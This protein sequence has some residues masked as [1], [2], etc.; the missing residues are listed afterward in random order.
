MCGDDGTYRY[1]GKLID[2]S[3]NEASQRGSE[4]QRNP[5]S[6]L[7]QEVKT[8]YAR[9]EIDSGTYHRLMEMAQNGQLS[10][11]DLNRVERKSPPVAIQAQGARRKR[12]AEIV[13][14]L[15]KL[16]SRRKQLEDSRQETEN[17]LQTLEKE[18]S[19]L[20]DKARVAEEKAQE[21]IANEE[22]AR[23][24]LKTKQEAVERARAVQE[25]IDDLRENLRRV[26][27]LEADL[28][29]R[30]AELKALESGEQLA[31]LEANIRQDL[32]GDE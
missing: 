1:L 5:G 18:A 26:E 24:Y 13:G 28:A 7:E 23:A 30:E 8:L 10:W 3:L 22:V 20:D 9:G 4:L 15:N 6:G 32:L 27:R 19:R 29:T 31:E 14:L 12:D 2:H 16:Y 17:V 21:T 25:R 11:D